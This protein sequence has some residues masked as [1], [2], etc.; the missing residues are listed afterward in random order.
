MLTKNQFHLII[1]SSSRNVPMLPGGA[2]VMPREMDVLVTDPSPE[3]Q[4]LVFDYSY[5]IAALRSQPSYHDCLDKR[6]AFN[7]NS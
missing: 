6:N 4:I 1:S 2:N 3:I 7:N 5:F